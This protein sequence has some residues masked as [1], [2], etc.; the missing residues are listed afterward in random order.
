MFGSWCVQNSW[1]GSRVYDENGNG[2]ETSW[3]TLGKV[4]AE[5]TLKERNQ[6]NGIFMF[7]SGKGSLVSQYELIN[8]RRYGLKIDV[9]TQPDSIVEFYHNN[10]RIWSEKWS[11]KGELKEEAKYDT[12]TNIANYTFWQNGYKIVTLSKWND[13]YHGLNRTYYPDGN[14]NTECT[15][16]EG[17]I[18]GAFIWFSPKGKILTKGDYKDGKKY[19]GTFIAYT[20]CGAPNG[21][22]RY[23]NG[24]MHGEYVLWHAIWVMTPIFRTTFG[25]N[26]G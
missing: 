10:K 7:H 25:A 4:V 11:R 26:L 6:Y 1:Y 23:Q 12:L 8:G 2:T 13:I 9:A 20:S 21:F 3:D 16:K 22:Y 18:E 17:K 5:G 19:N 24:E 14:L 15:Y